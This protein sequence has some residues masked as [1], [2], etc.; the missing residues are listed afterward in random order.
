V[1]EGDRRRLR[2]VAAELARPAALPGEDPAQ[3]DAQHLGAQARVASEIL[4]VDHFLVGVLKS[5]AP[6][7]SGALA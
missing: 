3:Q 4:G 2:V 1:H 5:T 6:G 7:L